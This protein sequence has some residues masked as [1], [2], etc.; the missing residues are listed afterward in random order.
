MRF[1]AF[2]IAFL[3]LPVGA[4]LVPMPREIQ[5]G[6]GALRVD[7]QTMVIASEELAIPAGVITAALQRTTGALHYF[8]TQEEM[9][10]I[11]VP[12]AVRLKM[13]RSQKGEEKAKPEAYRLEITPEG[14]L[15]EAHDLSGL[16]HGVQ[17]FVQFLPVAGQPFPRVM[18]PSQ[19]IEDWPETARRIFHLDVSQHLFPTEELK[20]II[21]WLSFHKLNE[22]HLKLNGD[23][24]WRME[25]LKFPALHEFG[26]VRASTPPLADPAGSDSREYGGYYPQEKLRELA[27]Y[28]ANRGIDLVPSFTFGTGAAALIAAY[29]ELGSEPSQVAT[30]WEER[31]VGVKLNA[32]TLEFFAQFFAEVATIFPSQFVRLD[33]EGRTFHTMM[34][35]LLKKTGKTLFL[36][37][38]IPST[39]F[40]IYSRPEEAELLLSE[41]R[42]AEEGLNSLRQVYE[43]RFRD[44]GQAS[45]RTR[46]VPDLEKVQYLVFP[47]I[48]AFAEAIWLP[49]EERKYDDFRTRVNELVFRYRTLGVQSSAPYDPPSGQVQGGARV[50]SSLG[51]RE[52]HGPEMVFDGRGDSFFWSKGGLKKGDHV[53][54]EFP[55]PIEGEITMA[56]GR[57]GG[58]DVLAPGI[59]IDGVLDFSADGKEWDGVSEFFDGLAR[60]RLP[61]GTR[62]ARLRVFRPQEDP[63]VLHE[64]TLSEPLL[65]S[66]YSEKR[67]VKIPLSKREVILTFEAQFSEHPGL[68][69]EIAVLRRTYFEEWATLANRAGLAHYPQTPRKFQVKEGEPGEMSA[70]AAREWMRKRMVPQILA[71]PV[72]VPLWITTGMGSYILG[73]VPEK[74]DR[75][76]A[77]E[78]GKETGAFFQWIEDKYGAAVLMSVSQDCRGDR[79]NEPFWKLL[80]LKSL[81]ELLEQYRLEE[82]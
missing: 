70:E 50:T 28:A 7:V 17:T 19:T 24:G 8:R 64:I 69:D 47:R 38:R 4:A 39:D 44:V 20:G 9:G 37:G 23:A 31:S 25:S 15:I 82:E 72:A 6:E 53:T 49:F 32:E 79:Y 67:K 21:D 14:A 3:C 40:S 43:L 10:R 73:E 61:M 80:T 33:G 5:R 22:F 16:M 77:R 42:R 63:L 29:P 56:T 62:F 2:V 26:S 30:T 27:K 55:W 75:G 46:Y 57:A 60:A 78:G 11:V 45:L 18:I 13:K 76:K 34:R 66:P 59:L 1:L 51:G 52:G 12:R 41:K 48:A 68:R 54:I 58:A 81:D 35:E 71:Y 74:P 36:P 65:T